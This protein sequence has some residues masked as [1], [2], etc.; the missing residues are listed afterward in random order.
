MLFTFVKV[1][2]SV[3]TCKLIPVFY[4]FV[5]NHFQKFPFY[6]IVIKTL[7]ITNVS[8][9]TTITSHFNQKILLYYL[10]FCSIL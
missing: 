3:Q 5:R 7:Y 4:D 10:M 8:Y 2:R 9:N 6:F 1:D